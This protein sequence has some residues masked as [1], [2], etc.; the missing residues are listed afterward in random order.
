M[1]IVS[2]FFIRAFRSSKVSAVRPVDMTEENGYECGGQMGADS[3]QIAWRVLLCEVADGLR[4]EAQARIT[5]PKVGCYISFYKRLLKEEVAWRIKFLLQVT[6]PAV[7]Q[8]LLVSPGH[9]GLLRTP[10]VG[11]C[12]IN[13]DRIQRLSHT[14]WKA[15]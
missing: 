15:L 14:G 3:Q 10:F 9:T 5:L 2:T 11:N 6:L 7:F 8:M 12:L 1:R 13:C 4:S